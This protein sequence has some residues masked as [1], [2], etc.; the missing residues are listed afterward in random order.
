MDNQSIVTPQETEEA[1]AYSMVLE[2]SSADNVWMVSVP[3]LP[4]LHTHGDT[5]AEAIEMGEEVIALW[6]AGLQKHGQP[7]PGS[8]RFA[9]ASSA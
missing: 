9:A 2:W 8:R 5:R 3:E 1:Q 6:I 7:V 4:G